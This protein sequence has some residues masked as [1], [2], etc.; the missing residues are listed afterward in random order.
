ME[1]IRVTRSGRGARI[2]SRDLSVQ[3][4]PRVGPVALRGSQWH[5]EGLGGLGHGQPGEE[6]EV[7]QS[8]RDGIL[9]GQSLQGLIQ[10]QEILGRRLIQR[11]NQICALFICV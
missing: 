5:P 9:P 3:P 11:K 1:Q 6:A 7:D 8:R 4:G 10:G 2:R